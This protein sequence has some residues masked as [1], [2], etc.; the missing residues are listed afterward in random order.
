MG[1]QSVRPGDL[2]DVDWLLRRLPRFVS[3]S[4]S[5]PGSLLPG[6]KDRSP[7]GLG[8]S[9][10]GERS[11]VCSPIMRNSAVGEETGAGEVCRTPATLLICNVNL[12]RPG[13][14]A[15]PG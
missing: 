5:H 10:M 3:P 7:E 8:G 15:G 2:A 4:R 1:K 12:P 11:P 14:F 13:E 6:S 9:L